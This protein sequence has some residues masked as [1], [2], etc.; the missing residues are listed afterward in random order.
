MT[1]RFLYR[2]R[3]FVTLLGGAA[4][5]WPLLSRAQ[6]A[7]RMRHVG[8]LMGG[9][10]V[11]ARSRVAALRQALKNLGWTDEQSVRIDIRWG[12]SDPQQI[13]RETAELMAAQPDVIVTGTSVAVAQVLRAS[14]SIPVVFASITDPVGQGL[15]ASLARPGGNAT[16][17]AAYE[18]SLG[19]KWIETLKEM[20]P[21]LGR[22]AILYEPLTA[23]YMAGMVGSIVAAGPSF[24]VE[25]RDV[26]VRDI[27]EL[28]NAIATFGQQPRS[29]LIV[30][31]A[32]FTLDNFALIVALAAKYRMP[33]ILGLEVPPQLLASADEVFE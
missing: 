30:P 17:F 22:A 32:S 29:G 4:A 27:A 3:E 8:V 21:G 1:A 23:P 16:G 10:T 24:G 19:G 20:S 33:A 2:R 31:P 14:R 28:E 11:E 15:V 12:S 9:D 26:P 7:G 5:T 18:V 6:Q 13:S 25:V